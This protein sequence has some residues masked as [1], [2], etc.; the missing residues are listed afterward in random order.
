[1]IEK[2]K[3]FH[4]HAVHAAKVASVS[5]R[6]PEIG[7]LTIVVVYVSSHMGMPPSFEAHG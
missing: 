2:L 6:D 7:D 4:R 3:I 1:M 5:H